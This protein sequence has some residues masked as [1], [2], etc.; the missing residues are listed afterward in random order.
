MQQRTPA[1]ID[2]RHAL[3]PAPALP[4]RPGP[5]TGKVPLR[6]KGHLLC[7]LALRLKGTNLLAQLVYDLV[8]GFLFHTGLQDILPQW[9]PN[10][11]RPLAH[12]CQPDPTRER[13]ALSTVTDMQ[14]PPERQEKVFHLPLRN[15]RGGGVPCAKQSDW[16]RIP[17]RAG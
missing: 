2:D 7:L 10:L 4:V 17:E 6:V 9:Q 14:E 1:V 11:A 13:S 12:G 16:R 5:Q 8:V 3:S 15:L